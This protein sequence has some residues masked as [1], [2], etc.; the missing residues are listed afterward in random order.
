M[1]EIYSLLV[2]IL[3]CYGGA[4]CICFSRLLL[5]LRLWL[6]YKTYHIDEEGKMT[7]A[8]LRSNPVFTLL[9]KLVHCP[10]CVGFWLGIL[11]S[12]FLYSHCYHIASFSISWLRLTAANPFIYIFDGFL[13]S[14]SAW[15]LHLL[16]RNRMEG[17]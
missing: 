5:P 10:L 8:V 15:I 2:F 14:S 17:A 11:F 6:T 4:V 13:G 3:A 9:S 12:V 16:F 7:S 1:F